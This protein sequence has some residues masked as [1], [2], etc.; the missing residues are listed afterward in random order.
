MD[1]NGLD[2]NLLV[3]LR[4]LLVERHVTR[5]AEKLGISQPA[6]S[7]SLARLRELFSDQLLVRG[8][9]GL[10]LTPRA[11][12]MLAQIDHLMAA[13]ERLTAVP[14]HFD[15]LNSRRT[16]TL[17]GTDFVES[18]VLP[19]LMAQFQQSAPMI[20]VV[21]KD[22]DPRHI[23]TMLATGVLDLAIGYLP[24]APDTLIRMPL[25]VEPFV[26]I[27]RSDHPAFK[28]GMTLE[29]YVETAHVQALMR[30]GTMYTDAID[31][32][33]AAQGLARRIALWQPSFLAIPPVVANTDLIST[34]PESVAR[35]A[36]VWSSITM[37][38]V[39]L[40]L[41]PVA[42]AAYW[43]PRSRDDT[44]HRWLRDTISGLLSHT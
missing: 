12:D 23:E 6:M 7:A 37:H 8:P 34:I 11:E 39:P 9:L 15:P 19:L 36:A 27:A 30:D 2:L 14:A 10:T 32:A 29:R 25:F 42:L 44:G 22:P 43:H 40:E 28:E 33:L 35:V 31:T 24:E 1:Y 41:P 4:A 5:A 16:F 20:R 18:K 3:P 26:C 17:I 13:I 38:Q 21:F